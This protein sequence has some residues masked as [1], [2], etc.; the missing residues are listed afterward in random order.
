MDAECK[1]DAA[2]IHEQSHF[3]NRI[4]SVFFAWTVLFESFL[5]FC[6]EK[7][8][9]TVIIKDACLSFYKPLAGFVELC[10]NERRFFR[11]HGQCP[12]DLVKFKGNWFDQVC[13]LLVTGELRRRCQDSSIDQPRKNRVQAIRKC[14]LFCN[15]PAAC[16]P[17][18]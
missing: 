1:R 3:H 10:L 13:R 14:M 9:G 8:V 15:L 5:V 6:F 18:S 16:C 11:N 7:V 17:L 4:G 12:V 2:V